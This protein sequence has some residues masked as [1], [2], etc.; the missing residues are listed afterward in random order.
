MEGKSEALLDTCVLINFAAINRIDLL[1]SHPLYQFLIT[2]H[3]REEVKEHYGEQ[4]DAVNAAVDDGTLIEIAADQ[5][6]ELTDFAKLDAQKNLGTGECSAIA[7]AK[8]RC[9][10]PAIDDKKARN[11][12]SEFDAGI[13]LLSTESLVVELIQEGVL[14][15]ADADAIKLDWETHH[16][17]KLKFSSFVEK[18]QP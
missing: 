11:R 7:V 1:A 10:P 6:G 12:A 15:V 9:L 4:F 2:D 17:F 5:P 14:T 13:V 8:N 3:V 18:V 16:S